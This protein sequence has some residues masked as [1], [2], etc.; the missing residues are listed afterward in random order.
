MEIKNKKIY[1]LGLDLTKSCYTIIYLST[2]ACLAE[3]DIDFGNLKSMGI[4]FENVIY[5]LGKYFPYINS[6]SKILT[7]VKGV[8]SNYDL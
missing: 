4:A 8:Y 7:S 6:F 3:Q 5:D 1:N 2:N